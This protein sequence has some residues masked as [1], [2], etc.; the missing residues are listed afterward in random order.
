MESKSNQ[1]AKELFKIVV[2]ETTKVAT[3][4]MVSKYTKR[5]REDEVKNLIKCVKE[6]CEDLNKCISAFQKLRDCY[7]EKG[8]S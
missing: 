7:K 4:K 8:I 1:F 3:E 6:N 2:A 5:T